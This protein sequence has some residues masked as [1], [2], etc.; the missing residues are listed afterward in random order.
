[1]KKHHILLTLLIVAFALGCKKDEDPKLSTDNTALL[2]IDAQKYYIVGHPES[3]YPNNDSVQ[4]DYMPKINAMDTIMAYANNHELPVFVTYEAADTGSRAMP[5]V[6]Q[7]KL[8]DAAESYEYVKFFYNA[9]K[10][11]DFKQNIIRPDID[12][13]IVIG[14]ETDVCV[15]QTVKG[16][17]EDGK[18]VSLVKEAV[19]SSKMNPETS[20]QNMQ[21]MGAELVSVNDIYKGKYAKLQS[22]KYSV[23]PAIELETAHLY[24]INDSVAAEKTLGYKLRMKY[25]LK[26]AEVTGLKLT[27]VDTKQ[28]ANWLT[29]HLSGSVVVAG[30]L[31]ESTLEYLKDK[32][33]QS[34]LINNILETEKEY[35]TSEKLR[36]AT[37]KLFLFDVT[38]TVKL[39]FPGSDLEKEWMRNLQRAMFDGTMPRDGDLQNMD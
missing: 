21:D 29:K 16:L 3:Y 28:N 30:T 13:Y 37:L 4:I 20:L 31:N 27:H 35:E 10:H 9:L 5:A 39:Y 12:R 2:I 25:L 26:F 15:Y 36:N 1:M 7:A 22:P 34:W 38:E 19:Y 14:A 32:G 17:L 8:K 11:N 24:I 23:E 33:K 18:A 6:M